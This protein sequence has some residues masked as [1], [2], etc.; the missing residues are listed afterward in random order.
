VARAAMRAGL[1]IMQSLAIASDSLSMDLSAYVA[2][3]TLTL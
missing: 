1:R 2:G 3:H